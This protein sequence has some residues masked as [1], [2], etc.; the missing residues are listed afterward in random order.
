MENKIK[1][2][3]EKTNK[4]GE[5]FSSHHDGENFR[6]S[7]K[8]NILQVVRLTA[9]TIRT[10]FGIGVRRVRCPTDVIWISAKGDR[11]PECRRRCFWDTFGPS[12]IRH[13]SQK[14]PAP[15]LRTAFIHQ[16]GS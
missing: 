13:I 1:R 11:P 2:K 7:V 8:D 16:S 4:K 9:C 6:L 12:A 10:W 14:Q 5:K 3:H 15:I